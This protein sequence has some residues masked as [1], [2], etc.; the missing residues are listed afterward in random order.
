[1]EAGSETGEA[2]VAWRRALALTVPLLVV[3]RVEFHHGAHDRS[4]IRC[5]RLR[6]RAIG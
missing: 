4:A 6:H 2:P 3:L 1:M 5:K